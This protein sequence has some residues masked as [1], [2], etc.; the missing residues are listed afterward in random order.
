MRVAAQDPVAHCT[1]GVNA[2]SVAFGRNMW[3]GVVTKFAVSKAAAHP[4][5]SADVSEVLGI[6][7]LTVLKPLHLVMGIK[8][9]GPQGPGTVS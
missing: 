9:T 6:A 3:Q 7:E 2:Y 1:T 5:P 4:P 8:K